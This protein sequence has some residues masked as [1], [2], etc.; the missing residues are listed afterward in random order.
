MKFMA[1]PL[2]LILILSTLIACGGGDDEDKTT[3]AQVT[4]EPTAGPEDTAE[5]T[6]TVTITIGSLTDKTGPAAQAMHYIDVAL[7]D[8][9]NYY[10][11]NNLIPG[12]DL[13]LEEY[14]TQYDPGK[15]RA[16]YEWLKERGT[17]VVSSF[18]PITPEIIKPLV[19]ED[20]I[21]MFTANADRELLYP[22]GFL[23]A[24]ANL[25]EETAYTQLKWIAEN[26]WDYEADGPA[27]IGGAGWNDGATNLM[28]DAAEE[29]ADA[30]PDQFEWVGGHLTNFTFTWAPEIEALKDCD[31]IFIPTVLHTFVKE[32]AIAGYTRAT[33][34]ANESHTAFLGLISQSDLWDEV[35]G[36]LFI[37]AASWWGQGAEETFPMT[38]K[39]FSQYYPDEDD[40]KSIK[41]AGR[42]YGASA[43]YYMMCEIIKLAAERVGPQHINSEAIY[44]AAQNY[45][46]T[47]DNGLVYMNWSPTK[48][49]GVNYCVI[50]E[51]DE[52]LKTLLTASDWLA[53]VQK[54]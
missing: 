5:P 34:L 32:Y 8:V 21:V 39:L 50:S 26:H 53:I 14:D 29:Y 31:Y 7:A 9:V 19:E 41:E 38:G 43:S 42:S 28:F 6:E 10:N 12:V 16:G 52:E 2:I 49:N 54:P 51:A 37:M 44:D 30:H 17:D 40:V 45:E 36:T 18:L 47:L 46:Y 22:P 48:R 35:N 11:D 23:F 4:G 3:M 20:K 27:K 24:F 13:K 1:I 15:V 25:W 33:F